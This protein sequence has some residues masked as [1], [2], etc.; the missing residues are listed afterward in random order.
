MEIQF[1]IIPWTFL[2]IDSWLCA[3]HTTEIAFGRFQR[4]ITPRLSQTNEELF[5]SHKMSIGLALIFGIEW[6]ANNGLYSLKGFNEIYNRL[7]ETDDKLELIII[8]D[9][10]IKHPWH[11]Y[12]DMLCTTMRTK[13][14][15]K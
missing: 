12:E 4:F 2:L 10:F 9:E 6:I 8:Q 15:I 11:E 7:P 5:R 13:S 14:C 3:T 1:L